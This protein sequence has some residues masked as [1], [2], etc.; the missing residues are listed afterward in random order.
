[1]TQFNPK[2]KLIS[3]NIKIHADS[4]ISG[5]SP[6]SSQILKKLKEKCPEDCE[7]KDGYGM[8]EVPLITRTKKEGSKPGSAGKLVSNVIAKVVDID[9]NETLG[10][11]APGELYVKGM[12]AFW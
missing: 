1:M 11:N 2:G 3:K 7:L 9:S 8:T 10:P 4:L 12:L 6:I 5:G